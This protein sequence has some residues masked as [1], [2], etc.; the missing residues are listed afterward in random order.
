M[1]EQERELDLQLAELMRENRLLRERNQKLEA[2][3]ENCSKAVS[4]LYGIKEWEKLPKE[5]QAA[6]EAASYEAHVVMQ[7]EYDAKNPAALARFISWRSVMPSAP[8]NAAFMKPCARSR[9]SE[10]FLC[11]VLSN[12]ASPVPLTLT[13]QALGFCPLLLRANW[14]LLNSAT[15][16]LPNLT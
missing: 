15:V 5:Y 9:I 11:V 14:A 16:I 2:E 13:I 3:I 12:V 7:A 1:T 10:T 8:L 6:V 4:D